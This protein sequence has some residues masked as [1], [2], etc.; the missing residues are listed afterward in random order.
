MSSKNK[1]KK[2]KVGD[3]TKTLTLKLVKAKKDKKNKEKTQEIVKPLYV[4]TN[5]IREA[6]CQTRKSLIEETSL[7]KGKINK[8]I[9][10]FNQEIKNYI[11]CF[12]AKKKYILSLIDM[13]VE[14]KETN[15]LYDEFNAKI[16]GLRNNFSQFEAFF[17]NKI[18]K[19]T[20]HANNL[21][22]SLHKK[23]KINKSSH[24]KLSIFSGKEVEK[25]SM[26]KCC[27]TTTFHFMMML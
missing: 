12:T 20:N 18:K 22:C 16:Q 4:S 7:L 25:K 17:D 8:D 27:R 1:K 13:V 3:H 11:E 23:S 9:P 26:Q 19:I 21:N 24:Q 14:I 10:S 2:N 15:Q 5:E 6:I